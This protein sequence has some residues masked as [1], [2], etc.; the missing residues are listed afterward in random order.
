MG[1]TEGSLVVASAALVATGT[2]ST[3]W[4]SD[5]LEIASPAIACLAVLTAVVYY[6]LVLRQSRASGEFDVL[7][8]SIAVYH[9][10]MSTKRS[11]SGAFVLERFRT[12]NR[13]PSATERLATADILRYFDTVSWRAFSTFKMDLGGC[14][15]NRVCSHHLFRRYI[16]QRH[17]AVRAIT[18]DI[19]LP[20]FM[21]YTALDSI[22]QN[23]RAIV[24]EAK[25]DQLTQLKRMIDAVTTFIP[26]IVAVD[27]PADLG[28]A[29]TRDGFYYEFF[30][31][32]AHVRAV[33][34]DAPVPRTTPT[35]RITTYLKEKLGR[36][37]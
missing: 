18:R 25:L 17:E 20:A 28:R 6:L 12:A 5:W 30:A 34:P 14:D 1:T 21:Y 19:G 33:R 37:A 26:M 35:L 2:S 15:I 31:R 27:L 9:E 8:R 32:E 4:L 22:G 16:Q 36:H 29:G 10:N 7:M 23:S 13:A 11:I 3:P 24:Q